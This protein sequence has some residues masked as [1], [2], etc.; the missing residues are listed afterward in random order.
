[1]KRCSRRKNERKNSLQIKQLILDR[2]NHKCRKCGYTNLLQIHHIVGF[3]LD[4]Q[5]DSCNL[6]TLCYYCHK[7]IRNTDIEKN[8]ELFNDWI[9]F[10]ISD[11]DARIIS[12]I[13][14]IFDDIGLMNLKEIYLLITEPSKRD[15]YINRLRSRII[16]ESYDLKDKHI[17]KVPL[18]EYNR[19]VKWDNGLYLGITCLRG[20]KKKLIK[21]GDKKYVTLIPKPDEIPMILDTF[22]DL[23][24]KEV[25]SKWKISP[26]TYYS[27]RKN[28]FYAGYIEYQGKEKKGIHEPLVDLGTWEKY[29]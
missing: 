6:I 25:C 14:S 20:Y 11:E 5:D 29:N 13:E 12:Y 27:I 4:G 23:D 18:I 24:Y 10:S 22:S 16:K 28:K 3:T 9:K 21:I 17:K 15:A 19:K 2:D 8:P 26:S 7:S 1:M